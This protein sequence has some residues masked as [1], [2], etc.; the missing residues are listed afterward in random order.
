MKKTVLMLICGLVL[1]GFAA[2]EF[3]GQAAIGSVEEGDRDN[4][5]ERKVL[6]LKF[7]THQSGEPYVGILRVMMEFTGKRANGRL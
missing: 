7:N 6:Y 1:N 3:R 5:A 2:D 4:K